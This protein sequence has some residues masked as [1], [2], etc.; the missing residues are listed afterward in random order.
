MVEGR[1]GNNDIKGLRRR[2]PCI[3]VFLFES[4]VGT[5]VASGPCKLQH[6]RRKVNGNELV[7]MSGKHVCQGSS[8]TADLRYAPNAPGETLKDPRELVFRITETIQRLEH[9]ETFK[10]GLDLRWTT[11]SACAKEFPAWYN[12]AS[13]TSAGLDRI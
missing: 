12:A 2:S 6:R 10:L 7:R 9:G 3:G 4:N 5:S 11:H 13:R 1:S 8:T